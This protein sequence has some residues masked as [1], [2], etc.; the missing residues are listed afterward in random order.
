[1][2]IREFFEALERQDKMDKGYLIALNS[3]N[4]EER[5]GRNTGVEFVDMYFTGS[6]LI[7]DKSLLCFC[8]SKR[9][10]V[11]KTE[12]GKY[13]YPIDKETEIFIKTE[14]I[15]GIENVEDFDDWFFQP[16][17][18]VVNLYMLPENDTASGHRNVVTIGFLR[19]F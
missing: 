7:C 5:S 2:E 17:S 13:M 18:K 4:L 12:T 16:C 10:P 11:G 19:D 9:G 15:A 8:N 6:K 3:D 1:M 14:K